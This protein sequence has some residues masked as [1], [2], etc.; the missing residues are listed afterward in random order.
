[1]TPEEAIAEAERLNAAVNEAFGMFPTARFTVKPTGIQFV[2]TD[3]RIWWFGAGGWTEEQEQAVL[4]LYEHFPRRWVGPI[5]A[6]WE[7]EEMMKQDEAL[8]APVPLDGQ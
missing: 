6:R 1:M 4:S 7:V 3:G 5:P 8:V 2:Q